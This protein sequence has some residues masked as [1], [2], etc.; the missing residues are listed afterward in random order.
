MANIYREVSPTAIYMNF[1]AN[2]VVATTSFWIY[3]VQRRVI[4]DYQKVIINY[5]FKIWE[6]YKSW[7]ADNRL[8]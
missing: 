1:N 7:W 4:I 3:L 5:W 2:L 6:K 8:S